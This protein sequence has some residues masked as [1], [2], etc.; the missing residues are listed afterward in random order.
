MLNSISNSPLSSIFS[1][2][3]PLIMGFHRTVSILTTFGVLCSVSIYWSYLQDEINGFNVYQQKEQNLI[4]NNQTNASQ[5][6]KDET[7]TV[8]NSERNS[9]I[10][11]PSQCE[12]CTNHIHT[13]SNVSTSNSTTNPPNQ[14]Q[15]WITMGLCFTKNTEMY[16]IKK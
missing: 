3:L 11:L 6:I 8:F 10:Y 15:I 9:T 16:G 13:E 14:R 1:F 2:K 4:L 7:E 12:N 5:V